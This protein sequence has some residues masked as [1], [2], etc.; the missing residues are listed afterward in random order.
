MSG[1]RNVELIERNQT[2][3]V[4]LTDKLLEIEELKNELKALKQQQDAANVELE[5][6]QR[7]HNEV[8]MHGSIS[9]PE[10]ESL[11][12]KRKQGRSPKS[13][14]EKDDRTNLG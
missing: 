2:L 14:Q 11:Q 7:K 4:A 5:R 12:P 8:V 3:E 1:D 13:K 9:E 6:L 10:A